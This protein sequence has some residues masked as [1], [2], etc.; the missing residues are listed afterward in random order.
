MIW[1]L[2]HRVLGR[3]RAEKRFWTEFFRAPVKPTLVLIG[4][5]STG[6]WVFPA[7]G[8]SV[9]RLVALVHFLSCASVQP[10]IL[11]QCLSDLLLDSFSR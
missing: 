11:A 6:E 1:P 4:V 2:D 3:T 10:A 7:L 9:L 5:G 8:F